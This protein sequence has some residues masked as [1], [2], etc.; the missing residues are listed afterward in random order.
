MGHK[1][2]VIVAHFFENSY[3]TLLVTLRQINHGEEHEKKIYNVPLV[4]Q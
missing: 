2:I 4:F 3:I 1:R